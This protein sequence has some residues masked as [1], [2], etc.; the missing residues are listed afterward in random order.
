MRY[1][2]AFL[3]LNMAFV[4][5]A[6]AQTPQDIVRW[7]YTSLSQQS[8]ASAQGL[9]YLSSPGQRHQFF[10]RQMVAFYQANES[11]GDDLAGACVD[12][13]FAI[14]GQ[15]YDAAEIARTLRLTSIKAADR[16]TIAADFST[17]GQ[18]VRVL[19]EF[20]AEDG[21]WKIDDIA[22][23]GFRVS[24]IPCAA[25]SADIAAVPI[26]ADSFCY[27]RDNSTLRLEL[28]NSGG[29]RVEIRSWQSNGHSCFAQLDGATVTGGW[30]FPGDLGCSLQLRVTGQEGLDV[31]DP[32]W[33]CKRT[34]CGQRA[35][36]EGLSFPR[37]SQIDCALLDAGR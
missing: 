33:A 35:T 24:E 36:L 7:V 12:Y 25:K 23:Q 37:S 29:A 34:L 28:T 16:L 15:D 11:Y 2:L 4:T 27:E 21:F 30:D 3:V 13:S 5:S 20:A 1:V 18:P 32:D 19:Y 17:F 6:M 14:P 31:F 26:P 10:S 22:G 9:D 8:A